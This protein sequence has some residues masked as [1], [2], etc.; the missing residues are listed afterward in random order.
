MTSNISFYQLLESGASH[1]FL[2]CNIS[3]S[4]SGDQRI[5][6]NSVGQEESFIFPLHLK[7]ADSGCYM[8]G[9]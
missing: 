8:V 4:T 2:M 6:Q 5:A 1:L 7:A 9:F 3:L